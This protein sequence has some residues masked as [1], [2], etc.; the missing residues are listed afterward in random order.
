MWQS[1]LSRARLARAS[2]D[3]RVQTTY[4][5]NE[6]RRLHGDGL[7]SSVPLWQDDRWW[8]RWPGRFLRD[9]FF[10]LR[11]M[12][13]GMG[14]AWVFLVFL[15]FALRSRQADW[16]PKA[17]FAMNILTLPGL[18]ALL[19][20]SAELMGLSARKLF[21]NILNQVLPNVFPLIVSTSRSD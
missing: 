6:L 12:H 15:P 2:Q 10:I 16:G 1:R 19:N 14:I 21:T 4:E 11:K 5:G 8:I 18:E 20:F 9:S 3:R 13:A 7:D 17:A